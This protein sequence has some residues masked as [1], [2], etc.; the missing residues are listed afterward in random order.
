MQIEQSRWSQ[1]TGWEPEFPGGSGLEAQLVLLFDSP[2]CLK[3]TRW[4]DELRGAY[5]EAHRLGCSTAGEIYG[6]EVE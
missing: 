3:Q 1:V 4:Q 6:S 2:S 5:P